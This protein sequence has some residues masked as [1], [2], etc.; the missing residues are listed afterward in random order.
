MN[1]APPETESAVGVA[2]SEKLLPPKIP[3]L[4]WAS[5]LETLNEVGP[6]L[7]VNCHAVKLASCVSPTH[8][9]PVPLGV[10]PVVSRVM[11]PERV[12]PLWTEEAL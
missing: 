1:S 4:V 5:V 10:K 7:T 3:K 9:P 12:L 8:H 11:D 2:K 6:P